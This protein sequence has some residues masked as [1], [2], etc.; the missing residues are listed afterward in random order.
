M[1]KHSTA[2]AKIES[3]PT[4]LVE[5]T[6]DIIRKYINPRATEAEMYT[7]QQLCKHHNLD[8]FSREAYLIK[9]KE[10]DPA[11]FV[12]GF[13]V[14]LKRAERTGLLNGWKTWVESD[15]DGK[16]TRAYVEIWRRDWEHPFT[17]SVL[18]DEYVQFK[19]IYEGGKYIGREPNRF[20]KEKPETMIR[21]V[22]AG[23]GFRLC[24]SGE[25]SGMPY[26]ADEIPS[27]QGEDALPAYVPP[28]T[29]AVPKKDYKKEEPEPE[30]PKVVEAP[31]V[32]PKPAPPA[33]KA[34]APKKVEDAPTQ[35]PTAEATTPVDMS[36]EEMKEGID[37]LLDVLER[38]HHRDKA[39]I[40]IKLRKR[41]SMVYPALPGD[42]QIP[43]GLDYKQS[44]LVVK[45]LMD[46]IEK[47]TKP[48]GA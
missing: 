29:D 9:Y 13:E 15:K 11:A 28:I 8:P 18:F 16:P 47:E 12:V 6:F 37:M 33:K 3:P 34:P 20:W 2:L 39:M 7:F 1:P 4:S 22:V 43:A 26:T 25:L 30:N 19:N 45:I 21:K 41:L 46:T 32:E 31:V 23:Q 40:L 36:L 35:A 17:H 5:L 48:E 44:E 42:L 27:A 38:D 24:F 10:G 14:Y